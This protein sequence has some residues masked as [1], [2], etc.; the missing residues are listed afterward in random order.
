MIALQ[1]EHVLTFDTLR[2][3]VFQL[4]LA[5]TSVTGT[6][7]GSN[8][9]GGEWRHGEE[10]VIGACEQRRGDQQQATDLAVDW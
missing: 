7:L 8:E 6:C 10:M 9:H 5:M 3:T 1:A 4:E 2:G